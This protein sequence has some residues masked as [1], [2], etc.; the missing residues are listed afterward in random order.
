RKVLVTVFAASVVAAIGVGFDRKR[1]RVPRATIVGFVVSVAL[2]TFAVSAA[3]AAEDTEP[4][5]LAGLSLSSG[6]VNTELASQTVKV[7]VHATDNLSGVPGP[8]AISVT[9]R[10]PGGQTTTACPFKVSGTETNGVYEG[11]LTFKRY[12]ESGAWSLTIVL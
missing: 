8:C 10:G 1:W 4:P 5:S 2:L 6:S 12:V 3:A 7:M 11:D 9:A